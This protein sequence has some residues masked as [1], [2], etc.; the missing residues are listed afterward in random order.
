VSAFRDFWNWITTGS[1]WSGS[2][3]IPQRLW[4]HVQYTAFALLLAAIVGITLGLITGHARRGGLAVTAL[5]NAARALP[6]LGIL[7]VLAAYKPFETTPVVLVLAA[8]ALPPILVNTYTGVIQA[9]EDAVDAARGM[10]MRPLQVL[11]RV[12]FPAALP[13]VW[14]GLRLA[15]F[16]VVSTATVAAYVALGGLGNF[17]RNGLAT[18]DYPQ[19]IGGAVVTVVL[20]LLS[21]AI[22][23]V[24]ARL[25]V[26]PGVRLR[27]Q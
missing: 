16:Q 10:G 22:F 23:T 6:T 11:F 27:S 15:A 26:S 21:L 19:V 18:R 13:L 1:H 9:D 14:L 17:I 25:T 8:L 24:A 12:E 7:Y 4:E 20:A 2:E 5:G 3:G